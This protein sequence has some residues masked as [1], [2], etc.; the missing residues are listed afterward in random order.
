MG[1]ERNKIDITWAVIVN[2]KPFI[3]SQCQHRLDIIGSNQ[4]MDV[5]DLVSECMI[6]IFNHRDRYDSNRGGPGTFIR[7]K[8]KQQLFKM[9]SANKVLK[10]NEEEYFEFKK[11]QIENELGESDKEIQDYE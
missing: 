1:E 7:I 8:T 6:H 2:Y 5:D 4:S 11:R 3:H 10:K 9:G